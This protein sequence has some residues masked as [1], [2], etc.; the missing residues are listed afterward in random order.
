[1]ANVYEGALSAAGMRFGIVVARFNELVTRNLLAGAEDAI[2]RC[3][4]D[5][6]SVDVAWGP[7]AFEIP[8]VADRMAESERYDVV[9]CLGAL[10]R[11][12]TSHYD[13]LASS[14]TGTLASIAIERGIPVI[15]GVLTVENIEQA[16]ERA[17]AKAGNKGHDAAM[18]AIEMVSLLQRLPSEE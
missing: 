4:G 14:V 15:N 11:G 10:I 17:G 12:A 6:A 2:R 8:I 1:M 5:P 13:H 16:L 3:G 9:I 18:S 7:G